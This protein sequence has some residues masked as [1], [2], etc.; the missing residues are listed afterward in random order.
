MPN[1]IEFLDLL[2]KNR[3]IKDENKDK[4]LNPS[5]E[6]HLYDSF[7]MKDMEKVCVRIFEAT[8]AKEKIVEIGRAHV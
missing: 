3:G 4:F 2:L 8:E 1:E 6:N 7:L 5:Y